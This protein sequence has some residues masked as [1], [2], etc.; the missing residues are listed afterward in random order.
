MLIVA[1]NVQTTM[2]LVLSLAD[3]Y[4]LDAVW[5]RVVPL[6]AFNVPAHL[7]SFGKLPSDAALPLPTWRSLVAHLPHPPLSNTTAPYASSVA[8]LLS[9]WPRDYIP[10]QILSLSAITL[11]GIIV[12]YFLF[13]GLSYQYIFNHEMME[14]PRF[15]KN[16]VKL[17][18]QSSL[19]AFPG[20]TLLT[21]PW[22]QAEVMGYSKLYENVDEYGWTYFI[23]SVPWYVHSDLGCLFGRAYDSRLAGSCCL[24]TMVSTGSTACSIILSCTSTFTSPTTNGLVR[25]ASRHSCILYTN[26]SAVP[27]PF[28]S[29]AFHPVDGYLQS[30]PYHL[31]IFLFPLQRHLYLALFVSVNFWSIFVRSY[32]HPNPRRLVTDH[33]TFSVL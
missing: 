7:S 24:P 20:M 26:M 10:R 9:A 15:L 16:Q 17:E 4:L 11:A 3:D 6:D 25:R 14:H 21:L 23:L 31:F 8:P 1:D 22:F 18:I 29:H 30:V 27:T 28:A 12:L 32:P 13:A 33:P 19:S 5:A 2:D